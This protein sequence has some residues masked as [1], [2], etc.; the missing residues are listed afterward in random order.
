M[1]VIT[2][3]K[4]VQPVK[5][6]G[7]DVVELD[8]LARPLGTATAITHHHTQEPSHVQVQV[9]TSEIVVGPYNQTRPRDQE[10]S[11]YPPL[12]SQERMVA[13]DANRSSLLGAD[14]M[15]GLDP[16]VLDVSD[17]TEN[18]CVGLLVPSYNPVPAL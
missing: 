14:M 13:S 16:V 12:V 4:L 18:R 6:F 8:G 9:L 7:V 3:D 2:P 17:L 11:I 10:R 5:Q 1:A 15:D